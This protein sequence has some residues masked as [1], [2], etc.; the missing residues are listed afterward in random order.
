MSAVSREQTVTKQSNAGPP[1]RAEQVGSMLRPQMLK[2]AAR[3]YHG[4]RIDADTFRHV[5]DRAIHE[6]VAMQEEVGLQSISDGEFRRGSWFLGFVEAVEGLTT[7]DAPFDFHGGGHAK[8]QTAYTE[9]KLKRVRGIT[10]DEFSFLRSVTSR[11][12]KVTIPSPSLVHFLRADLTVSRA[13][14]PDMEEFWNDLTAVYQEELAELARLGCSY[15]Q[16]DEVPCAMLCD[17][18]LRA[19]VAAA[20]E[21]PDALLDCYISAANRAIA[22]RPAGM[23]AAMHLCRGNYKG[24]WMAE[25]GYEPVADKLF[26][27]TAVDA[28]FLEY[29]TERAGGFEP[30][31]LVPADKT[32]VLGLVSTKT[33]ALE[34][35]D[36]LRRRIDEAS[37]YV[38]L[39]RL[40][41]SPQCGFASS[42]GGNPLTIE[43][44]R[45]KLRRVVEVAEKVWG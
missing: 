14:Y 29:D 43:D 17:P 24:Q 10:T 39:E 25:G 31:R 19:S 15:V 36:S 28:F 30:L 4:G 11:T 13:A 5:Q 35:I 44:E 22:Q 45:R 18:K 33:P 1:F 6:A 38:P 32:V 40:C 37:R 23:T 9:G 41:I 42:V 2:D 8:F 20:G 16:L 27:A 7:K 12:P 26:N 3:D 34:P 21:N